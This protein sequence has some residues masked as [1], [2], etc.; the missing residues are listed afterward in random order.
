MPTFSGAAVLCQMRSS[1]QGFF[2]TTWLFS[3]LASE[4]AETQAGEFAQ[5]HRANTRQRQDLNSGPPG[6]NTHAQSTALQ[7]HVELQCAGKARSL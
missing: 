4:K 1:A 6:I 7:L 3:H 2:T 5:I